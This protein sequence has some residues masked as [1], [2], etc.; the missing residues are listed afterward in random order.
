MD[1]LVEGDAHAALVAKVHADAQAL[2][3]KGPEPEELPT[4]DDSV[5]SAV[6]TDNPVPTPPFWGVREI[7]VDLDELYH[8][9]DTHVLFKLHWGGRG[10]K[11]EAWKELVQDDFQPRLERMWR[12]QDYLQPARA[13]R[14]LPLLQRGQRHRR[15]RP[16]RPRDASSTRFTCPRQPKHDRICLADYYRPKDAGEL[17]VVAITAVTS[18]SEVTELMARLEAEGEFA[19]QLFV[20]GLGVQTA[21]GLAEWLHS[22][23]RDGPRHRRR[24]GPALLVG[25]PRGARPVRAREG[26]GAARPRADRDEHLPRLRARARA[27]DARD[28]RPPSR[29]DLLRH[30]V[31]ARCRRTTASA[32]TT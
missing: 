9:L 13:A 30:E 6:R 1:Q 16:R 24:P 26:R 19:E 2:R 25:L 7:P 28:H 21:E 31:R 23:V 17:D 4:D 14:L 32:R 10:V 8:H 22:K 5:R 11:G 27:V 3:D 18:G 29:R 15:A 12:E 20:H